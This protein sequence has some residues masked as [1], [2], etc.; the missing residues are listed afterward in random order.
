MRE[1]KGTDQEE[2]YRVPQKLMFR[3][4]N[5]CSAKTISF[6]QLASVVI[7][8]GEESYTTNLRQKC[9]NDS[10]KAK[11]GKHSQNG[12]GDSSREKSAPWKALEND[13]KRRLRA[14]KVGN[15]FAEKEI[16]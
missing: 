5:Q 12:S 1:A 11:K 9:C 14:R 10:L 15:T 2:A 13:G 7:Q 16:E 4:D 8:E 3:C 6:W